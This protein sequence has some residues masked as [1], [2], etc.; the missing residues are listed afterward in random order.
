MITEPAFY[1]VAVP[2]VILTGLAKGGFLGAL[3]GFSVPLISLVISPIEAAGIMLPILIAMDM[4]G[5]AAYRGEYDRKNLVILLPAA[6][7]G[8]AIGWATAAYVTEAHVRL[9]VGLV[10]FVFAARYWLQRAPHAPL[11]GPDRL[12]G[13]FWGTVAGFT[14]FV[15][16][17][18]APP[19][20]VYML[21][22]R[23][24]N[25]LY[26]GT[27]VI[28]FA[29]VNMVKVI[30]Y[31]ALGQFS[32]ANLSTVA[33]LMPLAPIAMLAGVWLTRRVPQG[34]FYA[35]LH[36]GLL[37]VSAKLIYDALGTLL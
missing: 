31:A 24:P 18:G 34:P 29:T 7:A 36:A 9:I 10:G 17:T 5:L 14:S 12:K 35:V 16:H 26:A 2:A 20:Q 1:A 32:A 15:S 30:P 8:I 27:G 11:P 22:Q 25:A 37:I 19:F 4:V 23:L 28:F 6:L 3:G 21:P 13:M 33:V